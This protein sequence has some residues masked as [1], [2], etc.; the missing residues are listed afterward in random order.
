[1]KKIPHSLADISAGLT[2]NAQRFI[3]KS[4][5][6]SFPRN[7]LIEDICKVSKTNGKYYSVKRHRQNTNNSRRSSNKLMV[8]HFNENYLK[9]K[10]PS[11]IFKQNQR[12]IDY[13]KD[14]YTILR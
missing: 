7:T 3:F 6:T 12:K 8:E 10:Y 2:L 11:C 1:M 5:E 9:A 4:G 14:G 13:T